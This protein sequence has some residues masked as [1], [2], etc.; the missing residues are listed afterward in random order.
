MSFSTID[1]KTRRR[2]GQRPGMAAVA[3]TGPSNTTC[4]QCAQRVVGLCLVL[5]KQLGKWG[6]PIKADYPS[7]EHFEPR[8]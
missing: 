7:C 3:G 4:G 6:I 5:R 8:R 2:K 1:G